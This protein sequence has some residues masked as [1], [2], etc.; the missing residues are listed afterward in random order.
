MLNIEY[1]FVVLTAIGMLAP[2]LFGATAI[3]VSLLAMYPVII[4]VIET[5]F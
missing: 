5:S 1:P 4:E 2:M 3:L